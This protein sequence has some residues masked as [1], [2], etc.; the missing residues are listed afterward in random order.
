MLQ[1]Y[2]VR[3]QKTEKVQSKCPNFLRS[4]DSQKPQTFAS[5]KHLLQIQPISPDQAQ[6]RVEGE[7][8]RTNIF[9]QLQ[10]TV[11]ASVS[12]QVR[13]RK[14]TAFEYHH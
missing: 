7:H 8:T 11:T 6:V 4:Q 10:D 14:T 13:S 9:K 5:D 3:M 12:H 1:I 2:L